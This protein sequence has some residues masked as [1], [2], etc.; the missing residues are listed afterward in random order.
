MKYLHESSRSSVSATAIQVLRG[1]R[2]VTKV[3]KPSNIKVEVTKDNSIYPSC[4]TVS[5]RKVFCLRHSGSNQKY[6][7]DERIVK[8]GRINF[9]NL[10]C[11]RFTDEGGK[12][13]V[14]YIVIASSMSEAKAKAKK[15]VTRRA[16]RYSGL[17]K[18][19]L[20]ILMF[21]TNT[22]RVNDGVL[23]P[24]VEGKASEVTGKREI[25]VKSGDGRSGKY[26]LVLD[27]ALKY[28]LKAIKGGKATVDQ[29]M[30]KAMNKVVSVIN[31]KLKNSNDF[32]GTKKLDTP[33]PEVKQRK[34]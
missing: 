34:R 22:Q 32:F 29:Q 2:T 24:R 15:I 14:S 6:S 31:H 11:Y 5:K 8:D 28:A 33:F 7:G 3:A 23:N 25:L 4:T 27:D 26:G 1:L 16:M 17:A 10:H 21:K 30:K 20:S 13:A 9:K 18:R 12:K 19:A